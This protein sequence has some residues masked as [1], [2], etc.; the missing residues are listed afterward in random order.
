LPGNHENEH[1]NPIFL[2]VVQPSKRQP[3]QREGLEEGIDIDEI[4]EKNVLF[5]LLVLLWEVAPFAIR[6]D[7]TILKLVK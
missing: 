3:N 1:S 5:I 2:K 6:P 7:Y 4:K